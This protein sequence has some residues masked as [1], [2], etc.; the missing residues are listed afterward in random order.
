[1]SHKLIG[2]FEAIGVKRIPSVV[3]SLDEG[4]K[5]RHLNK[6]VLID[7]NQEYISLKAFIKQE[8]SLETQA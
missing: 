7:L 6:T 2:T 3:K 1:M 4:L 8:Y 5:K